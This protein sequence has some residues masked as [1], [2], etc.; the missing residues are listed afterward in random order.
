M[1]SYLYFGYNSSSSDPNPLKL[2]VTKDDG[3]GNCDDSHLF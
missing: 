3:N 1:G 2:Y